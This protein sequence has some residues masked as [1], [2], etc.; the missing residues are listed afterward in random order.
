MHAPGLLNWQLVEGDFLDRFASVPRP[1]IVF[2]DPFSPKT[3]AAL[4]S[5][6]VFASMARYVGAKPMML[7][8]YSAS[9]AV[10]AALLWAGFWV[11]EGVSTGSKPTTTVAFMYEHGEPADSEKTSA[12]AP[13]LDEAWLQRWNRSDAKY[14]PH[15]NDAEKNEFSRRVEAHRQFA[16]R[17]S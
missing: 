1:D 4:W 17:V 11:A 8:T 9:T 14:P 7:C 2:Y 13:W 3:D 16:I 12:T 6:D 5:A 15:L 10:R